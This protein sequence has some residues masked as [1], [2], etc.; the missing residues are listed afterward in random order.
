MIL[1]SIFV[2]ETESAIMSGEHGLRHTKLRPDL[3][4]SSH[5]PPAPRPEALQNPRWWVCDRKYC[6]DVWS[7]LP[8]ASL[9]LVSGHT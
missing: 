1:S 5:T 6:P 9:V 2:D 7:G 3:M 8:F 4:G